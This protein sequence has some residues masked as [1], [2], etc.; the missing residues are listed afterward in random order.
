MSITSKARRDARKRR[1]EKL[2]NAPAAPAVPIEPHAELRD[3]EGH[4]LGGIVRREGEWTLGLGG[5]IVR[6]GRHVV[7]TDGARGASPEHEERETHRRD[8]MPQGNEDG[9]RPQIEQ[10]NR[11][12]HTPDLR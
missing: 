7:E 10:E 1:L 6:R 2:R 9:P 3:Q 8:E 5:R 12:N 4:L 11:R